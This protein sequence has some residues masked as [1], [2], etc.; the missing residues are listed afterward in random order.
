MVRLGQKD[1]LQEYH[2][3]QFKVSMVQTFPGGTNRWH[4]VTSSKC[5]CS[6]L[7]SLFLFIKEH[8]T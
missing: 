6:R 8:S 4:R 3:L 5:I 2:L 1:I 7:L